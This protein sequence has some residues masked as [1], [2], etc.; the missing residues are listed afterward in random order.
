[1]CLTPAAAVKGPR[2][3]GLAAGLGISLATFAGTTM[4]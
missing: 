3:G 4:P 1:M 2:S